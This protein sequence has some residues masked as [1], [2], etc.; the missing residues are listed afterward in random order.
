MTCFDTDFLIGLIRKDEYAIK[1]LRSL[2]EQNET[3][4]TTP[5][6]AAELF[7][8]VYLSDTPDKNLK[9]VW[10]ILER[11]EIIDFN[12]KAANTYGIISS[13][14]KKRG[15]LLSEIDILIASITISHEETLLTKNI[16][17]FQRIKELKTEMW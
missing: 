12:M 2:I 11:L 17:H 9:L 6:N 13:N 5:I 16:K 1:K 4:T 14:L 3:L 8:G 10:G 7:K 15:E